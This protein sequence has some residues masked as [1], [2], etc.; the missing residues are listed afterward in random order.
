[1]DKGNPSDLPRVPTAEGVDVRTVIRKLNGGRLYGADALASDVLRGVD[2]NRAIIVAP[3]QAR[4]AWRLMRLSPGLFLR[5]GQVLAARDPDLRWLIGG[6]QP[7]RAS[8]AGEGG[9]QVGAGG[10]E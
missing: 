4:V 9:E 8:V 5:L 3:R 2:R 10:G 7:G 6:A 1:M